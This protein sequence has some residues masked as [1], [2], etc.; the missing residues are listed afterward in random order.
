M[1]ATQFKLMVDPL[2]GCVSLDSFLADLV[3]QP[4]VQRL[5]DV[6][7]SN[8]NSILLPGGANISRFE[9]SVGTALLADRLARSYNLEE[10][11]HKRLVCAALLHDVT[12]TPFGHLME[13]GFQAAGASFNHETRL[14]EIFVEGAE[15]GNVDRQMF[16]SR[17]AGFRGVLEKSQHRNKRLT[18][19]SVFELMQGQG[20]LGALIKGSIDLDN[21]DNVCRMSHHIGIPFRH[22]LPREICTGFILEQDVLS[23]DGDSLDLLEEWLDLRFRLYS[24]L[25]TNP[26]D[27]AAKAMLIEAIRLAL[28]GTDDA[29]AILSQESW[30]YTDSDLSN[31]LASYPPVNYLY[32]RLELGDLFDVLGM[33]WIEGAAQT[34]LLSSRDKSQHL[35]VRF[36]EFLQLKE[37]DVLIYWIRDK[38]TRRL[39][40][41][42]LRSRNSATWNGDRI[43]G[44]NSDKVLFGVLVGRKGYV[45]RKREESCAGFIAE[46]FASHIVTRCDS[47]R[48]L[49]A[50][51]SYCESGEESQME[52]F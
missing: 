14:Q 42:P 39:D 6:R 22:V 34:D 19:D 8:I 7:L 9:H 45:T 44:Q 47:R 16:R 26:V 37:R 1:D 40:K 52:L 30:S 41:L 31:A 20:P 43:I 10:C 38:R 13:E 29:P 5:R 51:F 4:E 36:A 23:Y 12:I 24:A 15:I 17:S 27:F 49:E 46:L 18:P 25:M 3:S 50:A 28:V 32:S 35:R 33:Y 21:I 2:Y 48:H 11:D